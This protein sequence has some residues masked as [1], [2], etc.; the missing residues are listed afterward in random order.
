MRQRQGL[1]AR[2]EH[3]YTKFFAII[4]SAIESSDE[5]GCFEVKQA[6]AGQM[7]SGECSLFM[8]VVVMHEAGVF[9]ES[10]VIISVRQPFVKKLSFAIL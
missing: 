7:S 9:E 1:K 8:A 4:N 6:V 5:Q 2:S 3:D 10:S